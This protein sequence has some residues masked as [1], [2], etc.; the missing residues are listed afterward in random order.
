MAFA[1]ENES[2]HLGASTPVGLRPQPAAAISD[3]EI[4]EILVQVQQFA[5]ETAQQAEQRAQAVVQAAAAEADRIVAE[6]REGASQVVPPGAPPI[7]PGAV[8]ALLGALDEFATTNRV[9]IEELAQ[10][11]QALAL[12]APTPFPPERDPVPPRPPAWP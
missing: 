8:A 11:R 4:G 12:A 9:L 2:P 6:A 5:D 1:V 10:L 3:T 7:P